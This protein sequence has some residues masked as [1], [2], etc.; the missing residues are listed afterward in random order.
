[1]Y[2]PHCDSARLLIGI[3]WLI[4]MVLV[5]TYSGSLV[6]FLTFPRIDTVLTVDD[7]IARKD[8]ITWGFPNGS[9]LETYLRNAEEPKYH[10]LLSRAR[11]HNDTEDEKLLERIKEGKHALIDWRS[12]LR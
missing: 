4:V 2:L 1:M 6:A 9:F 12:S 10:I 5:A 7:L 11:R 3:W 8:R